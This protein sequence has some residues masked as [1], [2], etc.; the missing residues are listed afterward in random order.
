[1]LAQRLAD[2]DDEAGLLAHLALQRGAMVL[3]GIGP[4]AGQIP[5]AALVQQQQHAALW[6]RTPLTEMGGVDIRSRA[7]RHS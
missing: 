3:A 2:L 6:I 7:S 4:A 5:F 1:M